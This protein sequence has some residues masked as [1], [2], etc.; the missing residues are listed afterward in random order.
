MARQMVEA[1]TPLATPRTGTGSLKAEISAKK[2]RERLNRLALTADLMGD[3]ELSL[4]Q[5]G[6]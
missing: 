5:M 3:F 1:S 2:L 6:H 4:G